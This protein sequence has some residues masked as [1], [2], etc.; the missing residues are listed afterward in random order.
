MIANELT[1]WYK[2]NKRELPFRMNKDPYSVWVS[3]IMAQQTRIETMVPYYLRWM[4][5]FPDIQTCANADETEI[6]KA[7]EGLGYY[8]RARMLWNGAKM[9]VNEYHG[10]FPS[11]YA[12][13]REI[14][15]IGDYT[16][17]AILSIAFNQPVPA[18]D[19]NVLRVVSRVLMSSSDIAK[20]ST[21]KHIT[22]VL[23]EWMVGAEPSDFTQGLMELGA[24]V[25]KVSAP[26]CQQCPI[27]HHCLSF[28]HGVQKDFPVKS[29]HKKPK[30][31]SYVVHL[32]VDN[33]FLLISKDWSDGL[34]EG[35]LRLPQVRENDDRFVI[36]ES[37]F[38]FKHVFSH[39]IWLLS[40]VK[41]RF[42]DGVELSDD[43]SWLP[44]SEIDSVAWISAHRKILLKTLKKSDFSSL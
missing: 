10:I 35:Y 3:E 28:Q 13:I 2:L 11:D 19:G 36:S 1:R 32:V 40:V 33:D 43:Y 20:D 4:A 26:D 25:C 31:E 17:A 34:M 21:K 5:K 6:L 37:L 42:T 15:G 14:P 39:K 44:I 29:L 8:R 41:S 23:N 16:A 9:I 22:N 30:S 24:L 18:V 38:S 12:T 7:W 27:R